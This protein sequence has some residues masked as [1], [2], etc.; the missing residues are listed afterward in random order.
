M[1]VVHHKKIEVAVVI[2]VEK[3]GSSAPTGIANTSKIGH[4]CEST[5]AIILQQ[6]IGLKIRD[7]QIHVAIIVIVRG[8]HPHAIA[9]IT[10]ACRI[11]N[12]LKMSIAAI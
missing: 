3:R 1:E 2:K 12:L 10:G 6:H 8:R 7:I 11:R 5:T 9:T 4:I